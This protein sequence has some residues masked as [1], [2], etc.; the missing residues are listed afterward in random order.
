MD[1]TGPGSW[2][3]MLADYQTPQVLKSV[4]Q[5]LNSF[6]PFF[7]T[8][9]LMFLSVE[10]SYWL[11]LL[12]AIPE[13][14]FLVRIFIIQHDCGH[15]SFFRSKKA[16]N[17]TGLFCSFLTWTPY[18]YW[19]KGHG[20]H[21]ANA[22]NL[23][24][25]GIGDVYTI[26][27]KEYMQ[28][29][30]WEKFKYRMYRHPLF[31]FLFIPSIIFILWY[32]FPTSRNKAF[33]KVES[34]IYWTDLVLILLA[35]TMIWMVSLKM[36]LL[37]QLPIIFIST[38]VGNWLFYVQHQFEETYWAN[39]EEWNYS[40]AATQGS[41]Y[42]KLPKILQWF[43]GNIGFHHIHHLNPGIPNYLLEK[44]YRKNP[45]LQK[46]PTLTIAKSFKSMLLHLWDEE[47]KKLISF[48]QLKQRGF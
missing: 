34:N 35:G 16:N 22:G 1:N 47:Q 3:N 2:R 9:Y 14:G 36:F 21:H 8:W 10:Y 41:S 46:A 43:S 13:A 38:S 17:L 11:T 48:R 25:R 28:K 27:V 39:K 19:R 20:I 15:G 23:E 44:C 31:L 12:L 45:A 26:T 18:F 33:K 5:L 24:G 40:K 42:Y 30:N 32:R 6:I 4:W 37:I 29:S 7:V